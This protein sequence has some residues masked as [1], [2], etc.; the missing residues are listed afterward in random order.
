MNACDSLLD[1]G[2]FSLLQ[3][4][5]DTI[6]YGRRVI[7][8]VVSSLS[9][10][11]EYGKGGHMVSRA[12]HAAI[13]FSDMNPATPQIGDLLTQNGL[14]YQIDQIDTTGNGYTLTCVQVTV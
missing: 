6:T 13:R 5:G 8:A 11:D 12:I 10:K 7:P 2:L 14:T 1:R 9:L 4:A 3:V